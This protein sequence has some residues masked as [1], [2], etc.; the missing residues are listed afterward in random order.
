V[1]LQDAQELH[2]HGR[3]HLAELV[4]EECAAASG[5]EE[6]R[7]IARRS[8]ERAA[9]VAE[10]LCLEERLRERAAVDRDE[11]SEVSPGAAMARLLK[12]YPLLEPSAVR[13]A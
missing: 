4:E 5:D 1:L 10:E 8:A 6:A 3:R 13:V 12:C 11:P 7:L 2:L 9:A